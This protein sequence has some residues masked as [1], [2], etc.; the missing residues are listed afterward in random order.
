MNVKTGLLYPKSYMSSKTILI[1]KKW[2]L[3]K[4][5]TSVFHFAWISKNFFYPRNGRTNKKNNHA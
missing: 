4:K 2:Y 1:S 5:S 3:K